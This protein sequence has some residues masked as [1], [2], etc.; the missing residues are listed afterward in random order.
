MNNLSLNIFNLGLIL[1]LLINDKIHIIIELIII[2]R[3]SSSMLCIINRNNYIEDINDII[4]KLM[5][6]T[7]NCYKILEN[8]KN[9]YIFFFCLIN[10]N[11]CYLISK[12]EDNDIMIKIL[13]DIYM[14]SMLIIGL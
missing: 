6:I 8:R 12:E 7:I 4:Y 11:L 5:I 9:I 3:I 13:G 14:I 1:P 2:M 10:S